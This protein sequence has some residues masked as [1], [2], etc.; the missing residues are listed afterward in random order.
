MLR[1]YAAMIGASLLNVMVWIV[2]FAL[3]ERWG[4][5][6]HYVP[7]ALLWAALYFLPVLVWLLL[8]VD[9]VANLL[10][11]PPVLAAIIAVDDGARIRQLQLW[12]PG[13]SRKRPWDLPVLILTIGMPFI[14]VLGFVW[15][16]IAV[17]RAEEWVKEDPAEVNRAIAK[18]RAQIRKLDRFAPVSPLLGR[19]GD[20][21]HGR[22]RRAI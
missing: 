10:G 7:V 16:D 20:A 14:A 3:I 22:P 1:Y 6:W 4:S 2:P 21:A 8:L 12:E 5:A 11:V 19:L 17:T 18:V 9:L 15:M 13:E